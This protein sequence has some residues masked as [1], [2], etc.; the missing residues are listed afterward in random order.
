[1]PDEEFQVGKEWKAFPGN[2]QVLIEK[3]DYTD[4]QSHLAQ[5]PPPGA[6]L[7]LRRRD[8]ALTRQLPAPLGPGDGRR[9]A[10]QVAAAAPAERPGFTIDW[11]AVITSDSQVFRGD[12]THFIAGTVILT[13][14]TVIEGNAVFKYTNSTYASRIWLQG[15]VDVRTG[16]YRPAFFV[17]MDDDTVGESLPWSSGTPSGTYAHRALELGYSSGTFE[18]HDLRFRDAERPIFVNSGNTLDLKHTQIT[19]STYGIQSFWASTIALGNVLFHDISSICL[20]RV[21]TTGEH[22]TFHAIDKLTNNGSLNLTN[23]LIIS[24]TTNVAYGGVKVEEKQDDTGVF[25]TVGA[26]AHYL[27][28]STYRRQGTN[29]TSLLEDLK[30]RTTYPPIEIT[31]DFTVDTL[32]SPTVLRGQNL[33]DLGYSYDPIDFVLNE[34]SV[35][36]CT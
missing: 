27:A 20:D 12:C 19:R 15:P 31:N 2:R 33:P 5:L 34:I 13:G 4:I 21:A 36:D 35:T 29:A 7:N 24:V 26:G 30:S 1:V 3:V 6:A 25:A 28:D 11:E 10:I 22:V 18:L 32:L 23:S 14:K 16:P 8:V 17:S 9:L